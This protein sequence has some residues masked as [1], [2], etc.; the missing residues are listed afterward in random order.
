MRP[1]HGISPDTS[2]TETDTTGVERSQ[3]S[4][5]LNTMRRDNRIRGGRD[6]V[7]QGAA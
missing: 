6:F 3:N 7:R 2:G 4:R 1:K 5:A